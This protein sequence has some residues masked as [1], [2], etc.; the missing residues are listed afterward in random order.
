[1]GAKTWMLV[2]S[3]TGAREAL[4]NAP[5]LDR[6]ATTRFAHELFPG[7]TLESLEDG[8]LGRTCPPNKEICIGSFPGVSIVAA[9]EFGVDSPS[10]IPRRFID[11]AGSG[12][13]TLHAMHS[14]V[15][16]FAFACWQNGTLIRSLSV[17]PDDGVI[18]DIGDKMAFEEPYWSGAHPAVDDDEDEDDYPLPF[19]PL[20][21]GEEALKEFFGYQLEGFVDRSLLEPEDVTLMTFRRKRPFWKFS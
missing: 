20:E 19:H 13:V 14:V 17:S 15:D 16:W 10:T 8:D 2:Y 4:K 11:A 3:E 9:K 7:E 21:L 12:T 5:E 1:M 6:E 18:E